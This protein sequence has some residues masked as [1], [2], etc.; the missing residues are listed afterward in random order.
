M[1]L[2]RILLRFIFDALQTFFVIT[3]GQNVQQ[4][5]ILSHIGL[6]QMD[7]AV[8]T[9]FVAPITERVNDVCFILGA[10]NNIEKYRNGIKIR[11]Q[12]LKITRLLVSIVKLTCR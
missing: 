12:L 1:N 4:V 8:W 7:I 9:C 3:F 5:E 10:A 6:S 2:V 11:A